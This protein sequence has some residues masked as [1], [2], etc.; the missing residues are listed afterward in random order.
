M[1]G[2]DQ[3]SSNVTESDNTS[4]KEKGTDSNEWYTGYI[5]GNTFTNKEVKYRLHNGRAIF[6]SD[7]ILSDTPTG[8]E[9]LRHRKVKGIGIKDHR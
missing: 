2:S 6:E 8:I 7:I 3:K 4:G 1:S 5:Q 9:H